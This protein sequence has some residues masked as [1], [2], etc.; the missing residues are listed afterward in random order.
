M[1]V[2]IRPNRRTFEERSMG[3]TKPVLLRGLTDDWPARSKWSFEY[4]SRQFGHLTVSAF[5]GGGT[6][7][8]EVTTL[9]DYL[10]R[11]QAPGGEPKP[12]LSN[13]E[14]DLECPSL[15]KDYQSPPVFD[16]L[17]RHVPES[18][19]PRWRWIY[20]GP[21]GSGSALHVDVAQSSAWNAVVT[22]LKRWRFHSPDQEP[23]LNGGCVDTFAPDLER[24]PQYADS[25]AIEC[26]QEPG[27]VVFTP[28]GWWHQVRN[29]APG[30]SVTEN[31]IDRANLEQ[32]GEAARQAGF[33][34][35]DE[36]LA[37]MRAHIAPASRSGVLG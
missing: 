11:L 7:V 3:L 8:P 12:Y 2:L 25:Q 22:G 33:P 19:R 10:Q 13:W 29:E 9:S 17:E 5:H 36:A 15:L 23:L 4:F 21:A 30:I 27:D 16:R 35:I 34:G 31:F 14:F 6:D 20:L 32:V 24:F 1:E 37:A 18:L 28:G 26:L